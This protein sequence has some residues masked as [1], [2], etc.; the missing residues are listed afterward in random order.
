MLLPIQTNHFVKGLDPVA[1]A[2]AGT[3]RSKIVNMGG[4][5]VALF[6][7][8]AGVGTTGTTLV[9]IEASDDTVP[10]NVSAIP[11]YYRE[12]LSGDTEGA[13]TAATTAGFTTTAG[14]SRIVE[15]AVH[16]SAMAA[17]GYKYLSMKC[18]EQTASAVLGGI[19]IS[20]SGARDTYD[21]HAT[22]IL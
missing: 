20:L 16:A 2:F 21:A 13:F 12:V 14:S 6:L 9:T 15:V 19:L 11:F 3:V 7:I 22:A 1:N 10:T 5:E 4:F 17:S 8:F 18:V